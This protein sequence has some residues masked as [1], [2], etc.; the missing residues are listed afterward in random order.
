LQTS[1]SLGKRHVPRNK[2]DALRIY[3]NAIVAQPAFQSVSATC[4]ERL[5]DLRMRHSHF[6]AVLFAGL[7]YVAAGSVQAAP[8]TAKGLDFFEKKIRPV[9]V[10][11]CYQCHSAQATN[12]KG[13]LRLDTQQGLLKG[14]D[15]GAAVVPGDADKSLLIEAIKYEGL[16]MPPKAKLSDEIIA[17]FVTWI[18]MGAP[19]PRVASKKSSNKIDI[20]EGRKFW[21]FQQ[22]KATPAPTVKNSAWPRTDIDKFVLAR[23]EANNIKP[24]ADA[25]RQTLLRRVTLD[26]I[27]LPPTPEEI[28]AF[29]NDKSPKAFET[30][31]D[32]LLASP[33]FGE[34]WGRH[35][36]DVA[37][38]GESTGKE[39]NVPYTHAWRYRDYV[40]DSFNSDKPY[41]RFVQEQIAGDLLPA[42]SDEEKRVHRIAT[43]FLALGPKGLNER[44]PEQYTMDN[45]DEQIDT[46][47]RAILGITVGCARCHDHKFDSIST[48]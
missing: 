12:V 7:I 34:R 29:L 32:R 42:A 44:K 8:L 46:T 24:V 35:W 28:D 9:L 1:K 48:T 14:G 27:G 43:G 45:V 2:I 23:L 21:A 6:G 36:L 47:C 31:V 16:E 19:D 20:I 22:P 3:Y 38:Y 40:I 26:L 39:R 37:R 33:Q 25:D 10:Q 4:L 11:Q 41:N 17:D 30:V 13:G 5:R 15:S 18:E